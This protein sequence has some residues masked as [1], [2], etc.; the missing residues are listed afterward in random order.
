[1]PSSFERNP[2]KAVSS[3]GL[4]KQGHSRDASD[5]PTPVLHSLGRGERIPGPEAESES[6][7]CFLRF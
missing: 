4:P 5:H 6:S 3:L 7:S 2:G 1:M